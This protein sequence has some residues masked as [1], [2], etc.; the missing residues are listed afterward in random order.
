MKTLALT[1][2]FVVSCMKIPPTVPSDVDL[3]VTCP[4]NVPAE[5][6]P[7]ADQT[8]AFSLNAWGTQ[9][10]TC[11]GSQ[12]SGFAWTFVTPDADL[13]SVTNPNGLVVHHF[14]GP[15]WLYKDTSLVV[16]TKTA[17]AVVDATAIPWL[18]LTVSKHGGGTGKL[19]PIISI[20]RLS[21]GGGLAPDASTCT[22]DKV[23][24]GVDVPYRATYVFYQTQA[25]HSEANVRCGVTTN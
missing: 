3:K 25:G 18:L 4:T 1:I 22:V 16:A 17:S 15:T 20:Q 2:L 10:Y 13:F 21:T 5:L 6:A 19:T 12:A 8:A 9:K 11:V 7:S 24:T 23:G 14:S